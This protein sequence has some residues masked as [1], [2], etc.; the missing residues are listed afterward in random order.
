MTK[1][2][3]QPPKAVNIIRPNPNYGL[4]NNTTSTSSSGSSNS[5]S[6]VQKRTGSVASSTTRKLR[7]NSTVTKPLLNLYHPPTR[8]PSYDDYHRSTVSS[9]RPPI[10]IYKPQ[11][12][13]MPKSYT[14]P[15]LSNEQIQPIQPT[16]KPISRP[17]H[18]SVLGPINTPVAITSAQND[19]YHEN[20]SSVE[21]IDDKTSTVEDTIDDSEQ[22]DED[23]EDDEEEDEQED[24]EEEPIINEARVNRKIADLELSINSLLSVNAMLESTVRKQA[25]QLSQMKIKMLS[26][27]SVDI[28]LDE[29]VPIIEVDDDKEEDWDQDLLFQKLR[30]ITEQMIEQGQKSIDFEYKILGRV[31]SN[32]TPQE[33]EEEDDDEGMEAIRIIIYV[34]LICNYRS[35]SIIDTFNIK[36]YPIKRTSYYT[37]TRHIYTTCC[38]TIQT[39]KK[40][41]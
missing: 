29:E 38:K 10:E 20:T 14:S 18:R 15:S 7:V 22:D 30:K 6:I 1:E 24:D 40:E 26:G 3:H 4:L 34:F 37:N 23:D 16:N 11:Q 41:E 31:L 25:S 9:N 21:V 35:N 36:I 8:K 28:I 2:P 5:G 17:S 33:E 32:Y 19:R 27:G 13:R 39:C 12:Q